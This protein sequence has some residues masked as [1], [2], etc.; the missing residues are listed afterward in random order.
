MRRR[1]FIKIITASFV[2]L[3]VPFKYIFKPKP[4]DVEAI[5]RKAIWAG[6]YPGLG[7]CRCQLI[8]LSYL[9]G[10]TASKQTS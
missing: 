4:I 2:A 3:A 10:K 6:Y 7:N 5:V 9:N 1:R 8:P